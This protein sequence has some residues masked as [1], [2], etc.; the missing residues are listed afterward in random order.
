[1]ACYNCNPY[2][3]GSEVLATLNYSISSHGDLIATYDSLVQAD[4][5]SYT[6]MFYSPTQHEQISDLRYSK[7]EIG[8]DKGSRDVKEAVDGFPLEA[9]IPSVSEVQDT[10]SSG[11]PKPIV[12]KRPPQSIVD[13]I[14]KAQKE[15]TGKQISLKETEV[16]EIII[17]RRIRKREI[18]VYNQD[19]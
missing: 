16:E 1:M 8:Y 14:L 17:K 10:G 12:I 6:A 7:I 11:A 15:V 9:Y 5:P 19:G 18:K 13:E 2:S 3:P 4:R